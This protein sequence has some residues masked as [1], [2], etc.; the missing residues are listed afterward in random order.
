MASLASFFLVSIPLI[1]LWVFFWRSV[2]FLFG[3]ANYYA[4]VIPALIPV[5]WITTISIHLSKDCSLFPKVVFC[6]STSVLAATM[7]CVANLKI[8]QAK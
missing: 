2:V 4:Q 7:W 8:S 3:I 1:V 5:P 6:V